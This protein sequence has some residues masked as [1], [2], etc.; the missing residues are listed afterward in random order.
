MTFSDLV[1]SVGTEGTPPIV[2]VMLL[3]A[4]DAEVLAMPLEFFLRAR[5]METKPYFQ[6]YNILNIRQAGHHSGAY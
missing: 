2:A 5:G 1:G 4:V 3:F 6:F